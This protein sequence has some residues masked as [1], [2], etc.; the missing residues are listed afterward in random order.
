MTP[1]AGGRVGDGHDGGQRRP[2][3][4]AY[5]RILKAVKKEVAERGY[6]DASVTSIARRAKVTR[7]GFYQ[8]FADKE[9]ALLAAF[10]EVAGA[11]IAEATAALEEPAAKDAHRG[12]LRVLA[13]L[14]RERTEDFRLIADEALVAGPRALAGRDTMLTELAERL[15]ARWSE[16]KGSDK[17]PDLPAVLVIGGV[18]RYFAMAL[19]HGSV[20]WEQDG[21]ELEA[22]LDCYAVSP[23]RRGWRDLSPVRGLASPDAI[24]NRIQAPR[25]LPRRG[26][27]PAVAHAA[28]ERE[29]IVHATATLVSERGFDATEVAEIAAAAGVPR[30]AFYRQFDSKRA[31]VDA[32]ATAVFE[33]SMAGMAG[34][35]F[36]PG[37]PWTDRIWQSS[38][39]LTTV[40]SSAPSFTHVAFIDAFA[41][42]RESA[43]RA[44]ELFLG[45]TIF[46][47]EGLESSDS[48]KVPGLTPRAITG[49]TIELGAICAARGR[50]ADLPGLVPLGTLLTLAPYVGIEAANAFVSDADREK[51]EGRLTRG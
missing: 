9:A 35:Y 38:W 6:A 16:A 5:R 21:G 44:D 41:P 4:D 45:F 18:I 47:T 22:W 49:A 11:L 33:Q 43:R 12:V 39:A 32:V 28:I 40:L 48:R 26:E 17:I 13:R 10:E 46:L 31:A 29:H 19:R 42:D 20:D 23:Q 36:A 14:A 3:S 7:P 1:R 37:R 50:V 24:G 51:R 25:H 2:P 34:A 30:E 27:V 15:E 8:Q